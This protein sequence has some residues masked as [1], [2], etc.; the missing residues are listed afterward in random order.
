MDGPGA[1]RGRELAGFVWWKSIDDEQI[2]LALDTHAAGDQCLGQAGRVGA[3]QLDNPPRSVEQRV[4]GG[5]GHQPAA[6]DDRDPLRDLSQFHQELAGH[7]TVRPS[8]ARSRRRL[9][10]Q[11]MP[12]ASR[13]LAG[14][15]RTR[16][17]GS[18]NNTVAT[19]GAGQRGG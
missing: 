8:P 10:I 1:D 14:S 18:P 13:P 16:I 17:S 5:V 6:V 4:E 19:T 7:S 3:P 2:A 9:R 12:G 15:S 11:M